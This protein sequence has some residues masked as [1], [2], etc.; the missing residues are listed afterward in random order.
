[1]ASNIWKAPEEIKT[2]V[3]NL[4]ANRHPELA[5][6]VDEICVTFREKAAKSGGQ[7]VFGRAFKCSDYMNLVGGTNYKFIIELAA[8][9]WTGT[10][11]NDQHEALLD[12]ILCSMVVEEDENSGDIKL[13]VIKPDIQAFRKNIE[14]YGMWFPKDDEE[15]EGS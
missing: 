12:S 10:L 5:L 3:D 11:T 9:E 1:M 15:E 13:G 6:V 8:D 14:K 2:Q 4:I 7:V